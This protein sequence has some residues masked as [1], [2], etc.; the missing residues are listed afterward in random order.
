MMRLGDVRK[1]RRGN[2]RTVIILCKSFCY[3][4]YTSDFQFKIAIYVLKCLKY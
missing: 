4:F 1:I 3:N 2:V